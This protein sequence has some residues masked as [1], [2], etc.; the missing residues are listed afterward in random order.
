MTNQPLIISTI[1]YTFHPVPSALQFFNKKNENK[2]K[3]ARKNA[4]AKQKS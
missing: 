4:R 2:K 3:N 1:L